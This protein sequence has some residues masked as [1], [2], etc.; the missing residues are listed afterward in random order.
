M[1]LSRKLFKIFDK[2]IKLK[3]IW[4]LLGI[5]VNT[6][7][8]ILPLALISPFIALLLEPEDLHTNSILSFI[9]ESLEIQSINH[10]LG[11][12][13]LMLAIL[14]IFRGVYIVVFNTLRYNFFANGRADFSDRIIKKLLKYSYTYHANKNIAESMNN[15]ITDV[16]S[17]FRLVIAA[18][19][20]FSE[21]FISIFMIIFLLVVSIEITLL[22]AGLALIC[23]VIYFLFFRKKIKFYGKMTRS[24]NVDMTKSVNQALG[25]IK[26]V[27]ILGR[28]DFFE[29]RFSKSSR[30]F[31]KYFSGQL[32]LDNAPKLLIETV[33]FGGAFL[34]LSIFIFTDV[35]ISGVL[36]ELSLFMVAAFRLLPSVSRM[37]VYA[38]QLLFRKPSVDAVYRSLF[39]DDDIAVSSLSDVDKIDEY[40]S[41]NDIVI[42]NLY[43]SYP[44]SNN[45][46]L[47]N[48]SFSIPEKKSV[49]FVGASG[50]GK[51]TLI[52]IILGVLPPN[53][54]GV[55]YKGL[56]IHHYFKEWSNYIGYIPQQIYLL[57]E[58][59][60][61][62]IAFGIDE[63]EIDN[64]KIMKAIE[65]AQLLDFV[66][67]LPEGID[68]VVGDRGIRLSGGQRQR[69]GIARAIYNDPDILVLDEATSA[70][71]TETEKAVMEAIMGF[72]GNKTLIIVA[73]RLTTIE[74]CDIVYKVEDKNIFQER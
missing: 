4:V 45:S 19:N 5:L 11:L 73:H 25:G 13:A 61:E 17:L 34:I 16:D 59:I 1:N 10:F 12:L 24:S 37:V 7:L 21:A 41:S 3:F 42:K 52:D 65:Q 18:T 40:M 23:V 38:N 48:L 30:V 66:K 39:L 58:T 26:E 43:F 57:D 2:K 35:D 8:E 20:F 49:A 15:V 63:P 33:C 22:V 68:T 71:D 28:E 62:N 9:N 53:E 51:T 46:I 27:K 64:D 36:P 70:L 50:A 31:A 32:A 72:K 44:K 29:K 69:I 54:G 67:S 56:S 55:Y 60:R 14:Y 47:E 6:I 74:N